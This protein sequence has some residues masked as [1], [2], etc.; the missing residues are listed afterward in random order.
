MMPHLNIRSDF[1]CMTSMNV[2]VFAQLRN[3]S[4]ALETKLNELNA[5]CDKLH[6]MNGDG[7]KIRENFSLLLK[8]YVK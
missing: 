7:R 4:E 1:C 8:N 6:K 5:A 2:N 3:S